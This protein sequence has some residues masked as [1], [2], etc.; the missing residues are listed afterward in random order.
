MKKKVLAFLLASTMVVEPFSVASAADFSDGTGQDVVQFSDDGEDVPEVENDGDDADQF[1]TDAAGEGKNSSKPPE[2]AIQMGDD[3]WFTFDDSTGTAT[4]S[5]TGDMWDYYEN[6]YDR[7]NQYMNPFIGKS[8]VKKIVIEDGVTSIGDLLLNRYND[9]KS[10]EE[11][12][13]GKDIERIGK[14]AFS[15]CSN[16]KNISLPAGLKEIDERVFEMCSSLESMAIPDNVDTLG[17][18]CFS[19]CHELKVVELPDDLKSIPEGAFYECG[20][21]NLVLPSKLEKIGSYAFEFSSLKEITLPKSLKEMGGSA[22]EYCSLSK[23][24]FEEGFSCDISGWAFDSCK[25]LEEIIIPEGVQNIEYNAFGDCL[26][27][28]SVTIKS[29]ATKIDSN[30]FRGCSNIRIIKGY[31]CSYIKNTMIL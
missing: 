17:K 15:G 24:N 8:G 16:I 11:I 28:T 20:V 27:L 29:A 26:N 9:K 19:E 6:G 4:I 31:D 13:L 10:I 1:S 3:V 22:F 2:D 25:N 23:L 7:T 5:G 30:V 21:T 12:L 14:S 18:L